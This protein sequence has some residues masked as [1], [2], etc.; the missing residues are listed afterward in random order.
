MIP[1]P[2]DP[3]FP[4][5]LML[6][7]A[8]A[9]LDRRIRDGH[10]C[11]CC[12]QLAKAYRR[13]LHSGIARILILLYRHAGT[14]WAHKPTITKKFGVGA[15]DESIAR[16]WGLLEEDETD[17]R[18]GYW[19]ITDKGARFVC[20]QITIQKYAVIYDAQCVN[21]E[22]PAVSITDC[23]GSLFDYDELMGRSAPRA[24]A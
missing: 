3:G 8:R 13:N 14:R 1:H 23:L 6:A 11:P 4:D 20:G 15:R 19:R 5:D 10:R 7:D 2:N 18:G 17:G 16:Y 21:L 24:A 9:A 12:S 22:G